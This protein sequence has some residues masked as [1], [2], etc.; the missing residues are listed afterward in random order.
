M[1]EQGNSKK[2]SDW[3]VP[4]RTPE[5]ERLLRQF[6]NHDGPKGSTEA[7]RSRFDATFCQ[8]ELVT[9]PINVDGKLCTKCRWVIAALDGRP[10]EPWS[11]TP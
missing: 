8:H 1:S 2:G 3:Q 7:F 9:V 11:G 10:L 4:K 5:T 6:T